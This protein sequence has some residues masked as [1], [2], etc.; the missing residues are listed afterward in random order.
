MF[1]RAPIAAGEVVVIWG[2]LVIGREEY[3]PA[4]H[5]PRG[6]TCIDEAHYLTT[7]VGEPDLVD[8][9]MNHSCDPNLWMGDEVTVLAMRPI[10]AGEELTMDYACWSD[11]E[12]VFTRSCGCRT[13]PCRGVIT[14]YDW[15][16]PS[17]QA[18]FEGHFLPYLNRRIAAQRGDGAT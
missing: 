11:Y 12:H 15:R 1:T 10:A 13:V 8:E 3:D 9:L 4:L 17:L 18:R 5:R 7:P 16:I 2:G 14:G 6:T